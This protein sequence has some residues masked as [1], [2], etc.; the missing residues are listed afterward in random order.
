MMQN[1]LSCLFA[2]CMSSLVRCL[3]KPLAFF[4]YVLIAALQ[5]NLFRRS[6]CGTGIS[7]ALYAGSIPGLAQW[8]KEM[9]L[10]LRSGP[11]PGNSMCCRVVKKLKKN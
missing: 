6:H 8:V 4:V 3:L 5:I 7:S 2:T 11:W 9:V 1:V 10:P